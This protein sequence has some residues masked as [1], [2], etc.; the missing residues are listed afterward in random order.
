[1]FYIKIISTLLVCNTDDGQY[2][3]GLW[4]RTDSGELQV[5]LN[6]S[7][8]VAES[9][10]PVIKHQ[11]L[12][13][14]FP[15]ITINR[16]YGLLGWL[17]HP[18]KACFTQIL[19]FTISVSHHLARSCREALEQGTA[20]ST[21]PRVVL[22]KRTAAR[23]VSFSTQVLNKCKWTLNVKHITVCASAFLTSAVWNIHT[24]TDGPAFR[25]AAPLSVLLPIRFTIITALMG[26]EWRDRGGLKQSNMKL[27]TAGEKGQREAAGR[28]GEGR[29]KGNYLYSTFPTESFKEFYTEGSDRINMRSC[30]L[31]TSV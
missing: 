18:S 24:H 14:L 10:N 4:C 22:V 26:V 31:F 25:E 13:G 29:R 27:K 30:F 1:M 5:A 19:A 23:S 8:L 20:H 16:L 12:F 15:I 11:Q 17:C 7:F 21:A 9:A 3:R 6:I 2:L 28:G